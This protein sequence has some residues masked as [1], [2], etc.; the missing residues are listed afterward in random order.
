MK[1]FYIVRVISEFISILNITLNLSHKKKYFI[2]LIFFSLFILFLE[3]YSLS[4]VYDVSSKVVNKDFVSNNYFINYFLNIFNNESIFFSIIL[5]FIFLFIKNIFQTIFVIFKNYYLTSFQKFLSIKM[6]NNFYNQDYKFF[7]SKNS[8]E[9]TSVMLQDISLF[10]RCFTSVLNLLIEKMLLIFILGY[11]LIMNFYVGVIFVISMFAYFLI[12][13][14]F[15]KKKLVFLGKQRSIL[16]E[17]IIRNLN[18]SFGNFREM[19]IYNC[20]N[21][22]LENIS[23]KYSLF[24]YNLFSYNIYQQTSKILIEQIFIIAII[25]IFSFLLLT[26]SNAEFESFVPLLAVYLF[27]FLRILPS[28]NKI[29]MDFQSYIFHKLFVNKLNNQLK[30]IETK[31]FEKENINFVN[32]LEFKNVYYK[33]DNA[34]NY[35][36]TNFNLIIEKSSKIGIIGKSGSGKTTFLNLLM[37]FINPTKGKIIVDGKNIKN[38]LENFRDN[39]AFVSQSTYLLDDSLIKNI[40]FEEDR[41][42]LDFELLKKALIISGLKNFVDKLPDGINTKLGERGSKIS[43][44]EILRVALARAVYSNKELYVLDEFTSAIDD[45]TEGQILENIKKLDKTIIIVSH[46]DSTLKYCDNIYKIDQTNLKKL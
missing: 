44:G 18:E 19:I 20:K 21:F 2:I 28:F 13:F 10:M 36:I 34:E 30:T 1:N 37:G 27:A 4:I 46:K 29:I 45:E 22:F 12:Y 3:G 31:K 43:G 5:L 9:M 33:F 8:S 11:L 23:V 6:I 25:I 24:F 40:C 41:N 26:N 16:N 32:S 38:S 7:I 15:T 39:I 17:G 14:L 35:I 42:K